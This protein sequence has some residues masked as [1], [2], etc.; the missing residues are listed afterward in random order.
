MLIELLD[1]VFIHRV[2]SVYS[3][4]S[5]LLVEGLRRINMVVLDKA[6]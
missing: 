4:L 2:E 5:L 6:L 3:V 1:C